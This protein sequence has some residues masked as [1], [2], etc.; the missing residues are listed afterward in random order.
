MLLNRRHALHIM[1]S[2]PCTALHIDRTRGAEGGLPPRPR[3]NMH[4]QLTRCFARMLTCLCYTCQL[5]SDC[6]AYVVGRWV[7]AGHSCVQASL[8]LLISGHTFGEDEF[9]CY[10]IVHNRSRL[11]L[12]VVL[13][14]ETGTIDRERMTGDHRLSFSL[15][16]ATFTR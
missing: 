14:F 7:A 12:S 16:T 15:S 6:Q 10:T 8:F 4:H 3:L 5:L 9:G 2:A 13:V 1:H 11:A